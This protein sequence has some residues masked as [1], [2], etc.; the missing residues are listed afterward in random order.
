MTALLSIIV[1][2]LAQKNSLPKVGYLMKVDWY[3]IIAYCFILSLIFLNIIV[4]RKVL[5]KDNE[6]AQK[7]NK[8]FTVGLVPIAILAYGIATLI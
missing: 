4:V 6:G 7:L 5:Q 8:W 2:H 3:F 1:Y